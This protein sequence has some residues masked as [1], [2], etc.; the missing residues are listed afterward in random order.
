M[1][2]KHEKVVRLSG[3]F[4][5]IGEAKKALEVNQLSRVEA[6]NLTETCT[7]H[8]S[9]RESPAL[10]VDDVTDSMDR[11]RVSHKPNVDP[12]QPLPRSRNQYPDDTNPHLLS[13][14]DHVTKSSRGQH[15]G[16][17]S[18]LSLTLTGGRIGGDTQPY[19]EPTAGI[20]SITETR[21]RDITRDVTR[22]MDRRSENPTL[23][24]LPV[25]V[26]SKRRKEDGTRPKVKPTPRSSSTGKSREKS[27]RSSRVSGSHRD[28]VSSSH[29][30]GVTCSQTSTPM[31]AMRKGASF[32]VDTHV[33]LWMK[34]KYEENLDKLTTDT[35]AVL[36][37]KTQNQET[38]LQSTFPYTTTRKTSEKYQVEMNSLIG[39]AE[40]KGITGL[41]LP[42]REDTPVPVPVPVPGVFH[43]QDETGA[44]YVVGM[45]A[46]DVQ[47]AFDVITR[48]KAGL[49]KH[50]LYV[51]TDV[52]L[53][54]TTPNRNYIDQVRQVYK[55]TAIQPDSR[56]SVYEVCLVGEKEMTLKAA[57]D[58]EKKV[59]DQSDLLRTETIDTRP[60][61]ES[62][63]E[64]QKIVENASQRFPQVTILR[65]PDLIKAI[66]PKQDAFQVK[67]EI[68]IQL[69]LKPAPRHRKMVRSGEG[70]DRSVRPQSAVPLSPVTDQS[71]HTSRGTKIHT[72]VGDI[73]K[74]QVT[75]VVNAAN[76]W[77]DHGA[78][79]A[80]AICTAAGRSFQG[81]CNKIVG[82]QGKLSVS[83]PYT[84]P[85]FDLPAMYVIHIV[86]PKWHHYHE[87]EK[88]RC[89]QTLNRAFYNCLCE[90]EDKQCTSIAI[91]AVSSGVFG[92]PLHWV[93]NVMC[94]AVIT[95]LT[96]RLASP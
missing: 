25:P 31:S 72:M 91:P 68:C 95:F 58:I 33:W 87:N 83:H 6:E 90:A 70:E 49:H 18:D 52:W 45:D 42:E 93:S 20:H 1:E 62:A 86:G 9:V 71:F 44:C 28:D 5:A 35:G 24:S 81:Y 77:L 64:T 4:T 67:N 14:A 7:R 74:L 30:D 51:D 76:E 10:G 56:D 89:L 37:E 60:S 48:G 82:T 39:T 84:T 47:R 69:G 15:H 66:G 12:P 38:Y 79:V 11:M 73:T 26:A 21:P 36:S 17:T 22:D 46:E 2:L 8:G 29:R 27:S 63:V 40:M 34:A 54:L 94:H 53:Y 41:K 78:G 43:G 65:L 85:G 75:A 92:V 16:M 19:N 96:E 80:H 88:D 59:L 3:S 55:L 50:T 32:S 13:Q 57:A 23:V 61:R